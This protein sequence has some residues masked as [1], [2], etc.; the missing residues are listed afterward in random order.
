MPLPLIVMELVPS[1]VESEVETVSMDVEFVDAGLSKQDT[2]A[3]MTTGQ[4]RP[5]LWVLPLTVVTTIPVL[6]L[7]P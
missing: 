1:G 4:D 3:G 2:P 5:T 7:E 6:L